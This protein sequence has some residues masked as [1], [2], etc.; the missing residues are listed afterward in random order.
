[1]WVALFQH[2]TDYGFLGPIVG[3][4]GLFIGAGTAILFGWTRTMDVFKPPP[5]VLDKA[6]ARVVTLLCAIGIF[7]AWFLAEPSNGGAYLWTALW[8]AILCVTS[9]ICYV[10]LRSFCGRFRKPMVDANNRPTGDEVIW[11]GFWLTKRAREAVQAGE[12]VERF[13]RGNLYQ[14]ETVWPPGSQTL[15]AMVTALV[16]LILLVS[17]TVALSTSAAATQVALTKKP[18]RDVIGVSSVPGLPANSDSSTDKTQP[19]SNP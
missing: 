18:A 4:A 2:A 9:F 16:L 15:S 14:R 3:I 8:L 12:T 10:G 11:G 13:L 7:V 17:G 19:R 5:E 1:M 6:L